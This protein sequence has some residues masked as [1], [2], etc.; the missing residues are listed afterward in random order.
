LERIRLRQRARLLFLKH[1][2]TTAQF[3]RLK[4][5]AR[6]RKKAI[7]TLC[8][9][10]VYATTEEDK[11]QAAYNYFLNILGTPCPPSASVNFGLIGLAAHDLSE[12]E[13]DITKD[14]VKKAIMASPSDKA[15]G[16]DGFSATF[17]KVCWGIIKDDLVAALNLAWRANSQHLHL[18]N[19]ASII[20]LPKKEDLNQLTDFR[21]ISLIHSFTKILTKILALRLAPR[22]DELIGPAQSAFIRRRRIQENFLY[23]HGVVKKLHRSKTPAMLLKIDIVKA[24]DTVSWEFL[25]ELLRHLGFGARWRDCVS[26][27]LFTSS[28]TVTINGRD[29]QRIKLARDSGKGIHSRR[30]FSSL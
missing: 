4:I 28:T 1:S 22:M 3:F 6:R 25:L 8:H 24:F 27:L 15:P 23:V 20:L 2:G 16:P 5:N 30:C 21:P 10:G 19:T 12:L 18:V 11:L 13:G 17:F 26:A 29:T 9:D 7:P 14:E